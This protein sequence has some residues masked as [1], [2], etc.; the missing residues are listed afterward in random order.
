MARVFRAQG[1][2]RPTR[3]SKTLLPMELDTAMSPM[4]GQ[5]DSSR[6]AGNGRKAE[7][8]EV[9]VSEGVCWDGVCVSVLISVEL[10]DVLVVAKRTDRQ[11]GGQTAV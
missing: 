8:Q 6:G 11:T 1:R 2:P 5:T 4:P 7:E 9:G 10:S 3:M